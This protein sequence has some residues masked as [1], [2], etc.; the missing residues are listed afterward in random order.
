VE[1]C[2]V[3]GK[4]RAVRRHGAA[5]GA[6]GC[7]GCA[8]T[9]ACD[10]CGDVRPIIIR[11]PIGAA[12][13]SC[14]HRTRRNVTPCPVCGQPQTLVGLDQDGQRICSGCAGLDYDYCC[15]RCHRSGLVIADG[16]CF[17]CLAHARI[18]LLLADSRGVLPSRLRPLVPALLSAGIGEAV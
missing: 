10:L 7:T 1:P 5:G 8:A 15:S 6:L 12:C 2:T 3:C 14:Y 9:T 13:A 18:N 17:D 4:V 11:W 16:L